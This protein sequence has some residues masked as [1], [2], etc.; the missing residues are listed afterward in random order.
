MDKPLIDL[1]AEPLGAPPELVVSPPDWP[2][3][4]VR[5]DRATSASF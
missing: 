5:S 2:M 4:E 3:D 1:D